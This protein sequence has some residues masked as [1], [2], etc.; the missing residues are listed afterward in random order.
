MYAPVPLPGLT[1]DD[2]NEEISDYL[3]NPFVIT[4]DNDR[5]QERRNFNM[6]GSFAWNV[7]ENLQ[8]KTEF[9]LDNLRNNDDRFYGRTTYYAKNAPSG[10]NQD[11]PAVVLSDRDQI[12]FRN[13]NTLNYNFRN[14]LNNDHNLNLL[15]GHEMIETETKQVTSAIH[16]Y[17]TLFTSDEAFKLTTQG[18]PASVDNF[19]S[20]DDKLLSFFGR[21]NY[22]FKGK[23]L[24]SATYRADGSSKFLSSNRWGYFP[25]AA[26]AWKISEEA[27]MDGTSAWLNQLKL[28]VSY[29]TAGNNNIPVARPFSHLNR[30]RT[31]G[32]MVSKIIGPHPKY[33][34]TRI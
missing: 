4:A 34:Q 17:P 14:L 29:G 6:A 3:I 7:M 21:A 16:G 20:P 32:S 18:T 9:G 1:T 13:T 27:F 2:T 19:Y 25:S 8:F 30:A 12:R 33:W 23:Y 24:L 15:V 22:E 5:F 26:A 10:E 31:H 28:R 11:K